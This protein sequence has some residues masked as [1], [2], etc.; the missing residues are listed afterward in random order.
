M[1][2]RKAFRFLLFACGAILL[3]GIVSTASAQTP[4]RH[5]WD[6]SNRCE[7]D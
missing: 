6:D 1:M 7:T 5:D 3:S 4:V 2:I